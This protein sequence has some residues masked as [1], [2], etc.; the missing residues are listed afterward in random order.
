MNKILDVLTKNKD[1][2]TEIRRKIH[3]NPELGFEEQDTSN[4]VAKLLAEWGYEVHRGLARTGVVGT[5]KVGTSD[6][7][8]GLRAD[9]DALPILEKNDKP[10]IS[11]IPYKF[12]G[13]GHD[14]HTTM[15]LCA[16]EY[17][18]KTKNFD[19][20]L[21]LIFQ[22]AEETLYGGKQM[23]DDGLFDLF[24]CDVIYAIHN[25]PSLKKGEFY[26]TKGAMM[27]SSDTV[28]IEVT[29]LG[30]H[31]AMPER[32]I[33][34]AV[35]ACHIVVALQTIVSRNVAPQEAAV[36]T[37]G[38]IQSGDV[39][40]V[41]NEKALLKLSVR[42]LH[43]DTRSLLLKRITEIAEGQAKSFDASVK[44]DHIN[45]SPV[46]VNG[47]QAVDFGV[48]IATELFGAEKV[49]TDLSP[50]MGSEDF[51]FMLEAHPN[52]AYF[53]VGN[54]DQPGNCMVHNPGYIFDDDIIIPAAAFWCAITQEYLKK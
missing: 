19:G 9:M 7:V 15:L 36:I 26:I 3:Q 35:V 22:P 54:G 6:K 30:G 32:T 18:A 28:H 17:L 20:T 38:S 10:W 53:F 1:K 4:L 2:Y 50:V 31:G 45:G 51:A 47:D 52:G 49:H 11:K 29:G 40:N 16:A 25:M 5:L 39:P 24:P 42:S 12:H 34:A 44:I 14:G 33:D 37:V 21:H 13:C 48:K 8:I 46:L 23:M 43:P 27:A 41:I